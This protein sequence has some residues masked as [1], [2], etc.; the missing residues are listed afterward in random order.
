MSDAPAEDV[1]HLTLVTQSVEMMSG[2]PAVGV[3]HAT[4]HVS[5]NA[6]RDRSATG[7]LDVWQTQ[8]QKIKMFNNIN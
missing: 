3:A 6:R 8:T 1:A 2:A 7:G 4:P 5:Q